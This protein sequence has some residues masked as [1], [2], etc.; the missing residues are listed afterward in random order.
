MPG[1]PF[2]KATFPVERFDEI[3]YSYKDVEKLRMT[4]VKDGLLFKTETSE[5]N[6]KS[7]PVLKIP[8]FQEGPYTV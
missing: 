7:K 8:R 4:F 3:F 6:S 5:R 2:W 1:C